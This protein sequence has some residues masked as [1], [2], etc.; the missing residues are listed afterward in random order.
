MNKTSSPHSVVFKY[1]IQTTNIMDTYSNSTMPL[2]TH[3]TT[4]SLSS[5]HLPAL[6]HRMIHQHI[7]TCKY[8]YTQYIYASGEDFI[9]DAIPISGQSKVD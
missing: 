7:H 3:A 6:I 4:Q 2:H 8:Q 9:A 5:Q 1:L